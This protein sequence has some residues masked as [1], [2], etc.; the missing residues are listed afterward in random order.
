MASTI[1]ISADSYTTRPES[2]FPSWVR[3]VRACRQYGRSKQPN[4]QQ[5]G[6]PAHYRAATKS[7]FYFSLDP[8][9]Q[10]LASVPTIPIC[11]FQ[12]FFPFCPL[13][14]AS[15]CVLL[16]YRTARSALYRI[17]Y[18]C[19]LLSPSSPPPFPPPSGEASILNVPSFLFSPLSP[20][21]RVR[22]RGLPP[23][24]PYL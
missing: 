9:S 1:C 2:E 3:V 8:H 4:Q 17:I 6:S 21:E 10:Y 18:L 14:S 19:N 12:C 15:P 13:A 22:V 11:C 23:L 7:F 24:L 16:A 5:C 20:R